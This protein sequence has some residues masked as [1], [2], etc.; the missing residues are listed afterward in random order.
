MLPAT[1]GIPIGRNSDAPIVYEGGFL[2]GVRRMLGNRHCGKLAAIL[3]PG[4]R[5]FRTTSPLQ[6]K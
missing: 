2:G 4:N 6:N 5:I 1:W 3:T